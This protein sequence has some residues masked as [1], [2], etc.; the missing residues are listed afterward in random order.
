MVPQAKVMATKPD[1]LSLIP[2]H[3]VMEGENQ[4][5]QAVL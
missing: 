1:H 5:P 4:L 2:G 3:H